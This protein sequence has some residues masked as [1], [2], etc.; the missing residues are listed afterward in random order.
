MSALTDKIRLRGHWKVTLRPAIFRPTRV[1][2]S[3]LFEIVQRVS[4]DL[5]GWDFPH[6]DVHSPLELQTE[7]VGQE[8]EWSCYL[9]SWR[10]YQSGQ[11]ADISGISSDWLDQA[12]WSGPQPGWEPGKTLGIGEVVFKLIDVF[13]FFAR[14]ALTDA[15]DDVMI[16]KLSLCGLRDRILVNDDPRRSPLW[17]SYATSMDEYPYSKEIDRSR[18]A[19][20]P[21][22]AA[23]EPT[24]EIFERFG[25]APGADHIRGW[26]GRI[27]S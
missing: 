13:E 14:L 19:A 15:G 18:L 20:E 23:L 4:V 10:F 17:R 25:W 21:R 24:L 26:Q 5:R 7:W 1:Q 27:R 22:E 16:V 12:H 8:S 2:Y 3:S 9:E 6:I 11:F